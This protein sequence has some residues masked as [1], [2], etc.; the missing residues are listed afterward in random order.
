MNTIDFVIKKNCL[1]FHIHFIEF[2]TFT[3]NCMNYIW[4]FINL[5]MLITKLQSVYY[6]VDQ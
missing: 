1:K 2:M 3:F 5:L 4:N 6:K